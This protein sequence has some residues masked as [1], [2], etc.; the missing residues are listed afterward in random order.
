MRIKRRD[1]GLEKAYEEVL[2]R[3]IKKGKS[4]FKNFI[5]FTKDDYDSQWFHDIVCEYLDKLSN[6]EIKKLMVF[7]PPQHGKTEISSRR[8]PAYLL[9]KKPSEKIILGSYNKTKASEFV[10]DCNRIIKSEKYKQ[11]FPN[12]KI[13]NG[14]ADTLS[15]F[16]VNDG[17][18]YLKGAGMDSGVTGTTGTCIIIDDPYKGRSQ[19]NSKVIRDK[20]WG[21]YQDDFKTRLDNN[22][23]E[24]MLFTRWHNDDLA[25]RILNKDS[26]YYD[27]EEAGE[28][29]V[30]VFSA[31]KEGSK[32]VEQAVDVDDPREIDE[33]LWE[34]KHSAKKYKKRRRINPTGFN[35][36]DQQRPT[37]EDGNKIKK[38]W[39]E[40]IERSALPFNPNEIPAEFWIDGAFTDKTQNDETA[41]MSCY[42]NKADGK[43]YI[44]NVDGVRKEL[45]EWLAYFKPFARA[46]YWRNTSQV[47]V[48]LKA[49]GESI[50]SMLSKF[51][52]GGF[53]VKGVNNKVVAEGKYNRVESSEP[54]LASGKVV[55]VKGA[56]NQDFINQCASFPNG[57]HD[58]KVDVLTYA[59]FKHFIKKSPKGV[60]YE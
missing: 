34:A 45:Y 41:T 27:E 43:L 39:F 56:W 54:F 16:E 23:I 2:N 30:L 49:S 1:K 22:G 7:M 35:S 31:L 33:A 20:T 58:D 19:A 25:G 47:H 6:R 44:F 55:L 48:E 14:G 3:A 5:R 53:N 42:F 37:A 21:V 15:Y 40:I 4:K 12:T 50:K 52:Y 36:L 28:W 29:T 57:A 46:N 8:F 26:E 32:A 11:L 13:D 18:G 17:E 59:I 38:E 51:E 24:L 60:S 9:G 10:K